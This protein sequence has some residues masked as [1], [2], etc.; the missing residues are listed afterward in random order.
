M[1][2]GGKMELEDGRIG[3]MVRITSE[4]HLYLGRGLT[5]FYVVSGQ[6]TFSYLGQAKSVKQGELF[7]QQSALEVEI[8]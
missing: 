6:V 8:M 2:G 3:S 4:K 5:I 1:R 7:V